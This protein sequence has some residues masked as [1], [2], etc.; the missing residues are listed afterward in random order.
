M[1]ANRI[2]ESITD[3]QTGLLNEAFFE[4]R[5]EEEFKKAW[6]FD[7]TYS[8]ILIRVEGLEDLEA[9]EGRLAAEAL[10]L[11]IAGEI[12]TASR[13]VDLSARLRGSRFAMLLPGTAAEGARTM[14]QRVMATAL[15]KVGQRVSLSVGLTQAP[16][17]R[18]GSCDEFL[19]RARTALETAR[20]QG[21]NQI[22]TWNSPSA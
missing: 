1:S 15:E 16:Q 3:S 2:L 17:D 6:R 19:A 9:K 7:W 10:V 20:R 18:L 5:L 4:L 21:L 12:L 8:L 11:D 13:D 14:I 22:V